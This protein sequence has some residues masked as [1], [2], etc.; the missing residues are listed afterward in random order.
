MIKFEQ[1][2]LSYRSLLEQNVYLF[3]TNVDDGGDKQPRTCLSELIKLFFMLGLSYG[4]ILIFSSF[5]QK[6]D[7]HAYTKRELKHMGP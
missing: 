3:I 7:N 6:C 1:K 4:E 5:G 2:F